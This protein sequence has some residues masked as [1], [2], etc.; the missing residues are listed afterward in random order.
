MKPETESSGS[1]AKTK[2]TTTSRVSGQTVKK[3]TVKRS[4]HSKSECIQESPVKIEHNDTSEVIRSAVT[5]PTVPQKHVTDL[6]FLDTV[7]ETVYKKLLDNELDVISQP[8]SI[9][10]FPGEVR[11]LLGHVE[12]RGGELIEIA[13][14]DH[15]LRP[16]DR[17]QGATLSP[18]SECV[19]SG[20]IKINQVRHD[21][22]MIPDTAKKI[23]DQSCP[24]S[25]PKP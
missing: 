10:E 22:T 7:K 25:A 18:A 13:S 3:K 11:Q 20:R 12:T 16:L 19:P 15:V 5:A 9:G 8:P 6:V 14:R 21:M 17:P 23:G 24:T 2:R 1:K 4:A